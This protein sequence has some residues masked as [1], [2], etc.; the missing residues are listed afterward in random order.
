MSWMLICAISLSKLVFAFSF[1]PSK[2]LD[3]VEEIVGGKQVELTI[4]SHTQ[5]DLKLMAAS[6]HFA[7]VL[8]NEARMCN[9]SDA[10]AN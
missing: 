3:K 6:R 9:L 8:P 10:P 1:P 5:T 7:S 4:S 2:G